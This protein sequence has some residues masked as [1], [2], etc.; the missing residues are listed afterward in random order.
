MNLRTWLL[1]FAVALLG[2]QARAASPG[3]GVVVL[4]GKGGAPTKHVA[5]LAAALEQ[6]GYLVRNLDMP[7]SARREY[8]SAV[9]VAEDEVEAALA[10]MRS[11]GARRVFVA[12]HSQG[13]L[14]ALYFGGRH[15]VDGIVAIAPGGDVAGPTVRSKLAGAVQQ[16]RELLANGQGQAP[17]RLNDYEGAKGLYPVTVSPVVYLSWFEPDGAMNETLAVRSVPPATPVLF[18][19]PT[20]DYPGLLRV[21]QTLFE[22]LAK[23]PLT[24]LYEPDASHLAAPSA[25]ILEIEAWIDAAAQ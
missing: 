8:D 21:K 7:W 1:V 6:H 2:L 12:G 22:Q 23:H 10:D 24:K 15:P 18:I 9:R 20:R 4:H 14:F 25:S 13:G 19:A 3:V 5:E 16:A 11:Q 17:V